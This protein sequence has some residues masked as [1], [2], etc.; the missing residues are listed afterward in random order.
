MQ[1]A[2]VAVS[3]R[4]RVKTGDVPKRKPAPQNA[5]RLAVIA[6]KRYVPVILKSV[7]PV[8]NLTVTP[9]QRR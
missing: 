6:Y 4:T 8:S 3:L 2:P 9:V 1:I 5:H 7:P